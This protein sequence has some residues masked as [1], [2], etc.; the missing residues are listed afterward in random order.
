[1]IK[2]IDKKLIKKISI[3]DVFEDK[4]LPENMK[5]LAFKIIFQPIE[6]TFTEEE[7]EKISKEIIDLISKKFDGKIRQ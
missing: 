3:F 6:K 1:M 5:S 2:K 4:T 7:I